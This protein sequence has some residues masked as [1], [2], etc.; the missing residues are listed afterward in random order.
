[1]YLQTY[2]QSYYVHTH[3]HTYIHT[4]IQYK[5]AASSTLHTCNTRVSPVLQAP[6]TMDKMQIHAGTHM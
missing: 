6:N 1:M 4:Y 5:P 3:T 2:I